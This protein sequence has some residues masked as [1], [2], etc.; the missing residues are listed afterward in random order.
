MPV[1]P[2]ILPRCETAAFRALGERAMRAHGV[3]PHT[4]ALSVG[5]SAAVYPIPQHPDRLLRIE[6]ASRPLAEV[7]HRIEPV[8]ELVRRLGRLVPALYS[9][10]MDTAPGAA[11]TM[12]VTEIERLEVVDWNDWNVHFRTQADLAHSLFSVFHTMLQQGIAHNDVSRNNIVLTRD[13]TIRVID[14]MDACVDNMSTD[15]TSPPDQY[16]SGYVD[17]TILEPFSPE[18]QRIMQ[19]AVSMFH[20]RRPLIRFTNPTLN[21][22]MLQKNMIYAAGMLLLSIVL[23]TREPHRVPMDQ[24]LRSVDPEVLRV[25]RQAIDLDL[26]ARRLEVLPGRPGARAESSRR[27][28]MPEP[29]GQRDIAHSSRACPF[30]TLPARPVGCPTGCLARPTQPVCTTY[31]LRRRTIRRASAA[32]Q[33]LHRASAAR[34]PLRRASAARQL[35]RRGTALRRTPRAGAGRRLTVGPKGG[36]YYVA[37]G[38]RHYV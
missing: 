38:V 5:A 15:C 16:T 7:A 30:P 27:R 28:T 32:R 35:P 12:I 4:C 25:I 2:K 3:N 19:Q 20:T 21:L 34:Q 10:E 17:H 6:Y 37:G 36:R 8:R 26:G 18:D 14:F 33:P 29:D 22:A 23:K 31:Q 11:D 9:I 24:V 1:P 13:G